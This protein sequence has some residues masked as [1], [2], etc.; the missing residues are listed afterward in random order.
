MRG[1]LRGQER[2]YGQDFNGRERK[3]PRKVLAR[4]YLQQE[5]SKN[6]GRTR[7][8]GDSSPERRLLES[9]LSSLA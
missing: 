6:R 8:S 9:L 5:A 4:E 1:A 3:Y 7:S 2:R